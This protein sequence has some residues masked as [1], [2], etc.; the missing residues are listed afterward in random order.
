MTIDLDIAAILSAI[1]WPVVVLIILLAYRKRIPTLVEGMTSRVTKLEFA[2]ISVELAVAKPFVPEW[3][4][5][6][7]ARNLHPKLM[8]GVER[9]EGRS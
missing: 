4:G 6:P 7:R 2:G 8:F 1:L 5:P 3:S 9:H